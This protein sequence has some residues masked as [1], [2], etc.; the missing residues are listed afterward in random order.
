M[1]NSGLQLTKEEQY[2]I[3]GSSDVKKLKVQAQFKNTH[4]FLRGFIIF[5]VNLTSSSVCWVVN[6]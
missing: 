4:Q 5:F 6:T 1:N 3:P 2:F